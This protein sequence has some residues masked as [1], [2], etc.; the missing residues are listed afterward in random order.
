MDFYPEYITN[1]QTHVCPI[2]FFLVI[3]LAF[4]GLC[5]YHHMGNFQVTGVSGHL[6][7][8]SLVTCRVPSSIKTA[9]LL[10]AQE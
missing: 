9:S 6:V 8:L 10:D 3:E 1:V 5:D 2:Y 7:G 4:I